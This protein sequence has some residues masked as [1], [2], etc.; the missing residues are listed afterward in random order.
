MTVRQWRW[1]DDVAPL[2]KHVARG[3]V[4]ALPTE[5]S[6]G[7]GCDP[8]SSVGVEAILEIKRRPAHKAMPVVVAGLEQL[9]GLGID[10]ASP[11]L[12]EVAPHWPAALSVLLE[13]EE[14]IAAAAS[15]PSLAVRV[16]DHADLRRLLEDLGHGL[17]ATSANR[18]GE[19]PIT[20]VEKLAGLLEGYDVWVVD[21][22]SQPG[23]PPSTLVRWAGAGFDLLR[24]G[25]VPF[26]LLA[27]TSGAARD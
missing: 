26:Q 10:L 16:P 1:R 17:T 12:R 2:R 18:S 9:A 6:Y 24:E 22:G 3:G 21:D 15:Q 4:V 8:R 25:R 27:P 7:L 13:L 14:P 11:G 19:A 20:T 23:G 5:S